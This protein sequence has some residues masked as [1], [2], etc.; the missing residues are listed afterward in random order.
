MPVSISLF[1]LFVK[2]PME[3]IAVFL[4]QKLDC[5]L[6]MLNRIKRMFLVNIIRLKTAKKLQ[7]NLKLTI[8]SPPFS[9]HK[10]PAKKMQKSR[11]FEESTSEPK[12]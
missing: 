4:F 6:R 11:P 9:R 7:K 8:K 12:L 2:Y 5:V 1:S 3:K 10:W